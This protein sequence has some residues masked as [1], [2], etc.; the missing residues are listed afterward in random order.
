MSLAGRAALVTGGG[1][2]LGLEMAR[3]LAAAG[4]TVWLNGRSEERL[5]GAV[6]QLAEE[7]LDV[8]PL[9]FDVGHEAAARRALDGLAHPVDILVNN[10][11]QRDRR[12]VL[13]METAAFAELVRVNLIAA[14]ALSRLVAERLV[15]VG[16]PGSVVNISSIAGGTLGKAD[17]VAYHAANAGTEGMTRALAADLGPHRIRVNAVAPGAFLTEM[18]AADFGTAPWQRWI[19][20]R[21]ALGRFG[22]PEE[23]AGVVVFLASD[24]AS[25][26]TGQVIAVDGG[27]STHY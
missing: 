25:Y 10:V 15:A 23:I 11:G 14:Y 22:R 5:R 2:G 27:V 17:D 19:R 1:R 24:A 13:E 26:V 4:A 21:S 7:G 9:P 3:G 12:G 8:R 6:A 20:S 18:N 16:R